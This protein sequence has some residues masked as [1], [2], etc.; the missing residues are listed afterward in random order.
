ML[1]Q[2]TRL[3][4]RHSHVNWALADQAMVS[5]VNFMTGILV[6]RYLGIEELGRFTLA[7]MVVLFAYSIQHAAINSPM[8]SIG[9][10][11]AE[12]DAPAYYGAVV[13]QQLVLGISTFAIVWTGVAL[14]DLVFPEWQVAG[15]ALPLACA[16]IAF[17]FQDFLRR[18]FFTRR[19]GMIAF[20]NDAVT[21]ANHQSASRSVAFAAHS[22]PPSS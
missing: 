18:C 22:V 11:Q 3:I 9:P 1:R 10:K 6:A 16:A 8:M 7:W 17:Q 15:L 20:T 12:A 19:R 4:G 21:R 5:A 14:S 2:A 13:F